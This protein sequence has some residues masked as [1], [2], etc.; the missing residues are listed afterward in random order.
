MAQLNKT[1]CAENFG[2]TGV[3]DCPFIPKHVVGMFI[4]PHDFTISQNDMGDLKAYLEDAAN[5][6][7]RR[8]RILPVHGFVGI[9]DNTEDLVAETLGYG[10]IAVIREGKYDLTFRLGNGGLCLLK[11]L[12]RYNN[13]PVSVLL[14]LAGGTI[15]GVRSGDTMKGIPVDM[16]YA[17]PLTFS[18]GSGTTTSFRVRLVIRPEYINDVLAFVE[19]SAD[20]F[21]PEEITGL[22]DAVVIDAGSAGNNVIVKVEGGCGGSNFLE[23][24]ETEMADESMWVVTDPTDGSTQTVSAVNIVNG[25]A[26]L[27]GA[28]LPARVALAPIATLASNGVTGYEGIATT[29]TA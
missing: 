4:V 7:N 29:I 21:I 12:R 6:E 23:D 15:L 25:V 14:I 28:E 3:G 17:L 9:E 8:E 18:D 11:S 1:L 27:V 10:G 24:Y 20:G 5:A 22:M 16:F 19:T 13:R 26:T 2:N